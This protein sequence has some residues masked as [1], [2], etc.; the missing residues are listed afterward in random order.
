MLP[1]VDFYKITIRFSRPFNKVLRID[2]SE[3]TEHEVEKLNPGV[4]YIFT[5][6]AVATGGR[7]S[8]NSKPV[9]ETTGMIVKR[10]KNFQKKLHIAKYFCF[11]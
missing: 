5:I 11:S 8:T 6:S 2:E 4:M 9:T 7:E 10:E 3:T 1:G